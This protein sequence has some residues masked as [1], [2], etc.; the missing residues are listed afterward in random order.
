VLSVSGFTGGSLATTIQYFT[1]ESSTFIVRVIGYC[2]SASVAMEAVVDITGTTPR[3]VRMAE[4][5]YTDVVG[6][7]GWNTDTNTETILKEAS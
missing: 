4:V 6:R 2:G 5:P 7:W 1:V 3:L